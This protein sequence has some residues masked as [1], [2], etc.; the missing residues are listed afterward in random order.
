MNHIQQIALTLLP[1]LGKKKIRTIL[2][3][4]EVEDFFKFSKH[5]LK[6]IRGLDEKTLIQL[7]RDL[8]IQQAENYAVYFERHGIHPIF[9]S[10]TLFPQRLNQCDDAPILLYSK[11]NASLNMSKIVAIVGTR[12]ATSYGYHCCD[13]L[14]ESFVGKDI[15]VV[16][17]LAYGIDNYVHQRC[18]SLGIPTVGVLG[19]GLDRIY[20]AVHQPIAQKMIEN[21]GLLSEFLPGIKPN[22]E[23]F[24]MR[25]RIV[26]GM[27]DATIVVESAKKGGSLITAELANDYSRDVFA[28]PGDISREYSKGCNYLIQKNKAHLITSSADFFDFMNWNEIK[29]VNPTQQKLFPELNEDEMKIVELLQ[30][31]EE[32]SIDV[33]SLKTETP[34]QILNGFLLQMEMKEII[35]SL[36]GKRFRLY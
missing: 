1:G 5:R 32:L 2:Q 11:G 10:D 27:C 24:P 13:E 33:I 26:A 31:K 29:K 6:T 15:L 22:R 30:E 34:L 17:G 7:N 18:V 28:Y 23:N 4:I 19:H 9:Y 3:H 36:P 21:G 16:S 35:K 20:P 25:N 8:A 14:L 12:N